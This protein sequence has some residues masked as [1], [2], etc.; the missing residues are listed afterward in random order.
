[1]SAVD[2]LLLD[3]VLPGTDAHRRLLGLIGRSG[4][5]RRKLGERLELGRRGRLLR[6]ERQRNRE[7]QESEK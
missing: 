1:V 3:L 2:E 6:G 4:R 5:R 7:Q